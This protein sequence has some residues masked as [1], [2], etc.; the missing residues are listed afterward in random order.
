[1]NKVALYGVLQEVKTMADRTYKVV[2]RTNELP[3]T[4]AG[5]L[6]GLVHD[7]GYCLF[8]SSPLKEEDVPEGK[9]EFRDG[10]SPSQRLR[11]VI[12][13]YW[14]QQ[15]KPEDFEEFRKKKMEMLID[16]VKSKL[17]A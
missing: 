8:S 4:D 17:D 1:M 10:K 9:P 14:E 7:E 12:Y 11:N 16:F 3:S 15:G 5:I 13:V 2:F 6:M